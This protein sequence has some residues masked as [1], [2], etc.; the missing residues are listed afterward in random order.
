M[1][2]TQNVTLLSF[3]HRAST[4]SINLP[5]I[6]SL[7]IIIFH[8]IICFVCLIDGKAWCCKAAMR[9]LMLKFNL[10]Y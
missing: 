9:A 6:L 8:S 4:A 2:L 7:A 3:S 1:Q 5:F 10:F